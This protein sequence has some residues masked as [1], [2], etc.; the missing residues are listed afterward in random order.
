MRASDSAKYKKIDIHNF[1]NSILNYGKELHNNSKALC[2]TVKFAQ[3]FVRK[4]INVSN[5]RA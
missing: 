1:R 5:K 4:G 3:N 2:I